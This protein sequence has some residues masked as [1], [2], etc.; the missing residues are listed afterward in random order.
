MSKRK[1]RHDSPPE[2]ADPPAAP[3]PEPVDLPPP[4]PPQP[5]LP[6]LVITAVLYAGWVAFLYW[7]AYG[8]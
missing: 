7:M 5:N 8:G 2:R 6:F 3:S 1:G 4:D